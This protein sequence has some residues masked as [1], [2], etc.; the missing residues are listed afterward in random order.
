MKTTSSRTRTTSTRTSKRSSSRITKKQM[1]AFDVDPIE[2]Q[3]TLKAVR[4]SQPLIECEFDGTIISASDVF[5]IWLDYDAKDL[6]KRSY[7]EL[8]VTNRKAKE[9]IEQ[10]WTALQ[11]GESYTGETEFKRKDGGTVWGK[12]S[13]S[14]IKNGQGNAIKA[15][16]V[17]QDITE[18]KDMLRE[19]EELR[20]RV[21]IVDSTSIV[22]EADLKGDILSINDKF[23][24]VSQY[25]RE[26]LIGKPH[27]TTRHP[28]MPKATF[29]ELWAT[30]GR[31]EKFRGVIKNRK[32]DGSPYYVDAVVAPVIGANGKPR[33]YIGVRYDITEAEI[34]RQ[35]TRGI[36]GAIDNA[37]AYIEFDTEGQILTANKNFFDTMGYALEEVEGKHHRLFVDAEYSASAAYQQ[38]WY[39]LKDGKNQSGTF[40]RLRKDGK[41][42][43]LQAVYAP[44]KDEMGRVTKIIKIA[45][46]ITQQKV[47]EINQNKQ[48]EESNRTQAVIEFTNEGVIIDAN[49]NFLNAAGYSIDEIKGK[50]HSM[51][52]ESEYRN[53]SEYRSFW[54]DLNQGKFLTDEYRRINKN[55]DEIWLQA[56]YNPVFDIN[57]KV[58]RVKKFATD[59]TLRKKAE[60]NLKMTLETIER[61]AG[62]LSS[63]SEELSSIAQQMSSNAE[64]TA[65]QSDVVASASEEVTS[66]VGSVATAAEEL[67]ASIKEIATNAT[68]A[69]GIASQAVDAASETNR[70][71][72]S[73]GESSHEIG[74]VIKVITSIAQQT[75]LLALNATIEAARAGDAGKGFAVVANEVK[76][77]A[78]QTA[79]ATEDISQKI[80][81]IQHDTGNAVGAIG[82]ISK[83][84]HQ[85]SDIQ[86]NIAGA[87][88]EQAA[89]TN[90]IA[91]NATEASRGSSE[92]SMNITNVSE[93][94]RSTTEGANNTLDSARELARLSAELAKVVEDANV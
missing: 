26:E 32:K 85:I 43:W 44:V 67:S 27:N 76:E 69:A 75:N 39:D 29:K 33:K 16:G 81:A 8:V 71:V 15:L 63:S 84:I 61:N 86:N 52:V 68:E 30:I 31:G 22:S 23:T 1:D 60:A 79:V 18:Q 34:E 92:I 45:T 41:E 37:Y 74:K 87:V 47:D 28:D 57:G 59:I 9:S 64:E 2:L 70:T 73:L 4:Q 54:E 51:F 91:R 21:D 5:A 13:F 12:V 24:E 10:L 25:S 53:S 19:L 58:H 77:L 80:A 3:G 48:I 14:P 56:T 49:Q 17:V 65:K 72:S 38:F 35:N 78:K 50:H 90:E 94:A 93:A 89:T 46:D 66:N 82:E 62:S 11:A 42:I 20:V 7:E 40:K 55:G 36:I 83:I 88:E 6:A